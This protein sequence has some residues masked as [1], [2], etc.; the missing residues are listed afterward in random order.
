MVQCLVQVDFS[1]TSEMKLIILAVFIYVFIFYSFQRQVDI[2]I[3][4]EEASDAC[5]ALDQ[6]ATLVR[7]DNVQDA[8]SALTDQTNHWRIQGETED[9][10]WID[11]DGNEIEHPDLNYPSSDNKTLVVDGKENV[12]SEVSKGDLVGFICQKERQGQGILII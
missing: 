2:H 4:F 5:K 11:S 12:V 10:C 8:M 6:S 1:A 7:I 3:N 9:R